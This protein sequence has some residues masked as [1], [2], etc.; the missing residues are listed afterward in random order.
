M[1]ASGSRVSYCE[2]EARRP[3]RR[4]CGDGTGRV[5]NRLS[6]SSSTMYTSSSSLTSQCDLRPLCC[7]DLRF[8]EPRCDRR[9]L[10]KIGFSLTRARIILCIC[11]KKK[12]KQ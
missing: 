5:L 10:E 2:S 4:T 1:A 8:F 9:K 3:K 11:F 12:E 6:S 7:G